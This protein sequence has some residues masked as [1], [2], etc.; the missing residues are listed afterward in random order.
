[1]ALQKTLHPSN[2]KTFNLQTWLDNGVC[3]VPTFIDTYEEGDKRLPKTWRMGQQY[4]SDGS[5]LYC[6][7][8]VPGWEGKPLIYTK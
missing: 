6:T 8:L 2:V 4:G 5:I 7:G 3:A 1:M